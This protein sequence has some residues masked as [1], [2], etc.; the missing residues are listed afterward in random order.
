MFY[1]QNIEIATIKSAKNKEVCFVLTRKNKY[2]LFTFWYYQIKHKTLK[3]F[4]CILY[5]KNRDMLYFILRLVAIISA[6]KYTLIYN[7]NFKFY[8]SPNK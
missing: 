3:E 1:T 7:P 2:K 4:H 6:K 8:Y 5:A